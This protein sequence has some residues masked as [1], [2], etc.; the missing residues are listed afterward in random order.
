MAKWRAPQNSLEGYCVN[1]WMK[2]EKDQ[3][4][5]NH[6]NSG[7]THAR[8]KLDCFCTHTHTQEFTWFEMFD[9]E[10]M[11]EEGDRT[12]LSE[13]TFVAQ[14]TAARRQ[15][16]CLTCQL[17]S[18]GWSKLWLAVWALALALIIFVLC[19]PY[20]CGSQ[21]PQEPPEPQV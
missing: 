21:E 14:V 11:S 9:K 1:F 16:Y 10:E 7:K 20:L 18:V 13:K 3:I 2:M 19:H 12:L 5:G 15:R 6:T 4:L 17:C 8:R